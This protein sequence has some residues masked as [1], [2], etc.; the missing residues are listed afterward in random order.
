M[1]YH[2]N[3]ACEILTT[4]LYC[5]CCILMTRSTPYYH[6]DHSLD[7]WNVKETYVEPLS[8]HCTNYSNCGKMFSVPQ[9]K[10]VTSTCD[11]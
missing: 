11:T 1:V 7:P 3:T 4:V 9:M 10:E 2:S 6:T 8:Q 5:T